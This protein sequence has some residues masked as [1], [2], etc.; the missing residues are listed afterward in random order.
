MDLT[1]FL[2]DRVER[3]DYLERKSST[4]S[5]AVCGRSAEPPLGHSFSNR[6][7]CGKRY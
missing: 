7:F 4:N 1:G 2:R 3:G 6:G 5:E